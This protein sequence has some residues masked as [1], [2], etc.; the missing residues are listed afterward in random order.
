MNRSPLKTYLKLC[1]EFYDLEQHIHGAKALSFYMHHA[2][3]TQGFILEPMCGTGRFLIPML[4]MGLK[5][6]GFDASPFMLKAFRRKYAQISTQKPPIWQQFVQD[7]DSNNRYSLIFIPYGSWG[8]IT[9]RE[10]VK[11]GLSILYNHLQ[12]GGT[13]ILEIETVAS[14]LDPCGIW[15]RGVH[16][17]ADGSKIALSTLAS[18]KED[19]Q[20]F[21]SF[22]RYELIVNNQIQ[23]V[24]NE[25]FLQYLYRFDELDV[26]L[27]DIGFVDIKKYPAYDNMQE[28]T[29]DTP[30]IMYECIK[31]I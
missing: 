29:K 10:D 21:Q 28:A 19:T 12:P 17:K 24:E 26:M 14:V 4:Q 16:T 23:E 15:R 6:E 18:Y 9:D 7:F 5:A 27:Q 31:S 11:K 20:I 8:L 1:T 2:K 3:Q 30:I 13:C 22:C 25:D